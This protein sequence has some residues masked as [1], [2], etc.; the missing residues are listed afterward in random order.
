MPISLVADDFV[1]VAL[2]TCEWSSRRVLSQ[3]NRALARR[4]CNLAL[5]VA[6]QEA[7]AAQSLSALKPMVCGLCEELELDRCRQCTFGFANGLDGITAPQSGFSFRPDF[8]QSIRPCQ[9][10]L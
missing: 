7:P 6:D 3:A 8:I 2:T 4:A 9:T 5:T 1:D 10:I